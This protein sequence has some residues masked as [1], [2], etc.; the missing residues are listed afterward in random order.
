MAN[1]VDKNYFEV[2]LGENFLGKQLTH[3]SILYFARASAHQYLREFAAIPEFLE[4]M[5]LVFGESFAPET[6]LSLARDWKR[7]DVAIPKIDILSDAALNGAYGGY[8]R[9]TNTIYLSAKFLSE[10]T[11]SEVTSAIL[12]EFGHSVDRLLNS[13]DSLGDEGQIFAALVQGI[14]IPESELQTLKQ[15]ND[16]AT[17]FIDGQEV[18]IE[19]GRVSDSGGFEGSY[20]VIALDTTGGGSAN[21]YYEHYWIPDN[22]IIRYEGRNIL[23]TGFVGG[24]RTG[25]VQIPDG[26]SNQ[27]EVIVATDD[28]G[29]AWYYDVKT[30]APGLNIQDAYVDV[31]GG[32]NQAATIKFPVLLSEASDTEITVNYFT[33]VGTAVDGVTGNDRID[34][35]PITGTLTFAPGETSKEVNISVLGDT[36]V[37]FGGNANFEIFAK[38]IA[39]Q[40]LTEGQDIDFDSSSSLSY[41]KDLGY[42]VNKFIN[43]PSDFQAAGLTSDENFFVLISDPVNGEINKKSDEEKDRL[44][45]A[46]EKFLGGGFGSSPA[47]VKASEVLNDLQAQDTSWTFATG[48]I[49]DQGKPP[50]L[51]IRGTASGQDAWDDT[52]PNGIGYAQFTGNR[53]NV[54]QWLHEVSHPQDTNVSFKP[55]ITGHSL[56]GALTQWVASDYSSQGALGDIVTFNAP[57]ISFA[58]A[59]SF[60]GAEKVTHYITSTDVVSMAGFGYISGQFILSNETFS[61]FNQIPVYGPHTHPVI[62][63]SIVGGSSKPSGLSQ[64][65]TNSVNSLLFTYLPDP[66]YFVFLLA[67]SKIPILGPTVATAL[68]TRGTAEVAR[69][70]IGAAL[71]AAD[72]A[73]EFAKETV[74]AAWNAAK[75]WSSAAW[76]AITGWGE[77]AWGA[78]S[79]WTTSAWNATTQWVDQAWDATKQLSSDAWDATKQWS[80]DAWDATKQWS[81]DAWDEQR[82]VEWCNSG[83]AAP[84]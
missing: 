73:I 61:T 56:G 51:A 23:E 55:N 65:P 57:G 42:R 48:T 62:V 80:S 14:P 27:L 58:G 13:V 68:L 54:N 81:S 36:P 26:D 20:K 41:G 4:K 22:F 31:A 76:N 6:A 53:G 82:P 37:N 77:A 3:D 66:D 47:Y 34:Y 70:T 10:S 59:N 72:F 7:G 12:E 78:V 71:Y 60:A 24:R 32:S 19:Q 5:R 64:G 79:N 39:Y 11:V 33:L 35:R 2:L 44:L 16:F 25:T 38:D 21:F 30:L 17:I 8:A 63:P 74:Q 84:A 15:E 83:G 40:N 28:E 29:T 50:V 49:Y 46:L 67:A 52:N 45:T 69:T 43:G 75:N 18:Q 1:L 9:L